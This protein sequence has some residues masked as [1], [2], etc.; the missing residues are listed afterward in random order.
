MPKKKVKSDVEKIKDLLYE[1]FAPTTDIRIEV[2]ETWCWD[3]A[4][5]IV[6]E[7]IQK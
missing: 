3:M 4:Q 6:S 7:I 1:N 2:K 5:R